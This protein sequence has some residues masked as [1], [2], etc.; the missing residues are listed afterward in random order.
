MPEKRRRAAKVLSIIALIITIVLFALL[1][2]S[3]RLR[4][5]G[6]VSV[7][8]ALFRICVIGWLIAAPAALCLAIA[9]LILALISV[10]GAPKA[11]A[12]L[13]MSCV[14]IPVIC[15]GFLLYALLIGTVI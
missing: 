14:L 12:P 7:F 10:G 9:A 8:D 2:L 4:F 15:T 3:W 6:S 5:Y 11:K 1:M 13:I